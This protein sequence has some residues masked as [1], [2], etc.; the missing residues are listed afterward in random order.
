MVEIEIEEPSL[1]PRRLRTTVAP[2]RSVAVTGRRPMAFT[3]TRQEEGID[4]W[5]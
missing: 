2:G 1:R 4:S 3:L 5:K